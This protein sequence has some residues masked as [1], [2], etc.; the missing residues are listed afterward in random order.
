M[1]VNGVRCVLYTD[2]S[3]IP[4]HCLSNKL[5]TLIKKNKNKNDGLS[6]LKS[7]KNIIFGD[8]LYWI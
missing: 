6:I 2:S 4:V 3:S 1:Y 5:D 7:F 8:F